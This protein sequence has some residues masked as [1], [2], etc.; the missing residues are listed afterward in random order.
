MC[1]L[2]CDC[3][4]KL[5]W[6][7]IHVSQSLVYMDAMLMPSAVYMYHSLLLV[8][9]AYIHSHD[10]SAYQLG[11][12]HLNGQQYTCTGVIFL[13]QLDHF[14]VGG[15]L[16]FESTNIYVYVYMYMYKYIC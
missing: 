13:F 6:S 8:L 12:G 3:L 5:R 9:H 14:Q 16:L 10:I 2:T 1:L 11:N 4:P 7:Y 15:L